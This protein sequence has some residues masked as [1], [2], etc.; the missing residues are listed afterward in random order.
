MACARSLQEV[1][2]L[3]NNFGS[4]RTFLVDPRGRAPIPLQIVT[5]GASRSFGNPSVTE[6]TARNGRP[7]L[8]MSVYVFSEGAAKGEAGPLIYYRER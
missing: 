5:N 8:F 3:P 7:A 2:Y 4:W 6:L 1:Q